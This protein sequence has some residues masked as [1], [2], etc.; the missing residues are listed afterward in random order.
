[1][2]EH[3]REKSDVLELFS[4]EYKIKALGVSWKPNKD[5]FCFSTALPELTLLTKRTLLSTISKLFDPMGLLAPFIINFK[6]LMQQL[7]VQGFDWDSEVDQKT[8]E[9]WYEL[10]RTLPQLLELQIPKSMS[11]HP[12]KEVQLHVFCDA[13]EK[14]Y[15]AAINA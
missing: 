2:Q 3:L 5:I 9:K 13:S 15:A 8:K 6:C 14:A 4:D 7:W 11:S 12:I 10:T 1:M